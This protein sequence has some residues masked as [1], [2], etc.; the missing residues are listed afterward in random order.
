MAELA[1][2]PIRLLVAD[3]DLAV[4]DA[5]RRILGDGTPAVGGTSKS[6]LG[7]RAFIQ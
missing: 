6:V 5:Y 7:K 1:R 4:L 2:D 3:D